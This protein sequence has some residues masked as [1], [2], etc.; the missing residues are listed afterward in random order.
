M[1]LVFFV[2]VCISRAFHLFFLLCKAQRIWLVFM[3]ILLGLSQFLNFR[4]P[5]AQDN[6]AVLPC[7]SIKSQ[8]AHF[9]ISTPLHIRRLHD[10][11]IYVCEKQDEYNFYQLQSIKLH[12]LFC[13]LVHLRR[14]GIS[15][16]KRPF[17]F[18]IVCFANQSADTETILIFCAICNLAFHLF[19]LMQNILILSMFK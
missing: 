15:C 8:I 2:R 3:S 5:L 10:D 13:Y 7:Q 11:D 6:V 12:K 1:A 19:F 16:Y 18:F 9:I 14:V 4:Q 17:Y